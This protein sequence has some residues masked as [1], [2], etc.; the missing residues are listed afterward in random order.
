MDV[1]EIMYFLETV[2]AFVPEVGIAVPLIAITVDLLKR[3]GVLQD[4]QAGI[5]NGVLNLA[6]WLA[7][8]VSARVGVGE[9][10]GNFIIELGKFAPALVMLVV[11]LLGT[12]LVHKALLWLGLGCSFNE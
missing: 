7:I 1:A 8:Y 10:F 4:G 12:K 9:E 6:F 5:A 3:Y 2:L 11:A